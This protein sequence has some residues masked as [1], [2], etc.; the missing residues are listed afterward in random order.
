[1]VLY[2]N[3]TRCTCQRFSVVKRAEDLAKRFG[4]NDLKATAENA[5]LE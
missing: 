5:S 2:S 1:V 4:R 3:W